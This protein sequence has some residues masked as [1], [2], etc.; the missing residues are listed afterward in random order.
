LPVVIDEAPAEVIDEAPAE[1]PAE[2]IDEAPAEVLDE[3]SEEI[4]DEL[5]EPERKE[6]A[7]PEPLVASDEPDNGNEIFDDAVSVEEIEITAEEEAEFERQFL[8]GPIVSKRANAALKLN[9]ILNSPESAEMSSLFEDYPD[10]S[11]L[12]K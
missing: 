5:K 3:L 2:V 12:L 9:K 8:G 10:I 11:G 1:V 6:S 4:P 7:P